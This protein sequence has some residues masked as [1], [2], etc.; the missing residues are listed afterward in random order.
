MIK[1]M[2]PYI[3]VLDV[4]HKVQAGEHVYTSKDLPGLYVC[5]N[6]PER[7]LAGVMPSIMTLLS[8][9]HSFEKLDFEIQVLPSYADRFLT[10]GK[11]QVPPAY[12]NMRYLISHYVKPSQPPGRQLT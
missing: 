8:K 12:K 1:Q 5:H 10:E 4:D 2:E 11:G 6:D 9:A 7:A 3:A